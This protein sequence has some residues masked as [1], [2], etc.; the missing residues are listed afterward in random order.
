MENL[1]YLIDEKYCNYK[2]YDLLKELMAVNKD[3]AKKV[4]QG[5]LL[6]KVRGFDE[7][8]FEKIRNQN[9]RKIKSFEEVFVHGYNENYCTVCA[10]QLSFSFNSCY[11]CGGVLEVLKNF[12]DGKDGS[13]TWMLHNGYIYDTTLMLIIEEEYSKK[14]GY[15]EENRYNPNM[16]P[17]YNAA[18]DFA[19]DSDLRTIKKI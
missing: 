14:L 15:I 5:Y 11:L 12:R 16:D 17:I 10:R 13:H 8:I 9:I 4:E 7:E 18:K 6:Q 19:T 2:C 1:D 3:F